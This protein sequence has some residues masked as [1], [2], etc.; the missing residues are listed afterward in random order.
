M[1]YTEEPM[2][3]N[4]GAGIDSESPL[5]CKQIKPVSP[6]ENQP[7]L[8][9]GRTDAEDEVIVGYNKL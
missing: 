7:W 9:I 3:S 5:D 2:L 1:L 8:F 4:C 6:K